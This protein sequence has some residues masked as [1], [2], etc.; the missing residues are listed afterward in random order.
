MGLNRLKHNPSIVLLISI[1]I[2]TLIAWGN[3]FVYDDAFIS[4]RY[5]QHLAEG[6]GLVWNIGEAPIEGYTN[7]LWTVLMSLA[8]VS[9]IDP[10]HFSWVVSILCFIGSL[11]LTYRLATDLTLNPYWG[12]TSVILVGTNFTFSAFATSGLET[13]LQAMLVLCAV[14]GVHHIV[15]GKR[16]KPS[17][18]FGIG[19]I[20]SLLLMVRLDSA[21]FIAI[22]GLVI[23]MQIIRKENSLASKLKLLALLA[24][25]IVVIVGSWMLWKL[26]FYGNLLPNTFYAKVGG[27]V[28]VYVR[29]ILYQLGFWSSYW[30]FPFP[31]L[32][33]WKLFKRKLNHLELQLTIIIVVW[34]AYL[35]YVGGD[36]MEFRFMVSV[37]PLLMIV[38]TSVLE[39]QLQKRSLHIMIVLLM[40]GGSINHALTYENSPFKTHQNSIPNLLAPDNTPYEN[41]NAIGHALGSTLDYDRTVTIALNPVGIIPYYSQA[42]TIDMLGLNDAWVARNGIPYLTLAAH[43]RITT[44][45]Y[46]LSQDVNL[47]IDQPKVLPND[48][49]RNYDIESLTLFH[50]EIVPEALPKEAVFLE[51]PINDT[52]Y[53][54]VLY[55]KSH[56]TIDRAIQDHNWKT[57]A[58]TSPS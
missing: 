29:G 13:Q 49:T 52:H 4:F 6:H 23:L 35:I 24:L 12:I 41:W 25:P 21:I 44:F 22:L 30:L 15:S 43:E 10:I 36:H 34:L 20:F 56:P 11:L 45:D 3:R 18:L 58:V 57:Y 26:N 27:K 9:S 7:F 50:V 55:L 14:Y 39:H 28:F 54:L 5:A 32:I 33:G 51:I 40:I 37:I 16:I 46:L 1:V 47:L 17:H 48:V 2:L 38:I 42:R 53:L 31:I 19:I 8:F